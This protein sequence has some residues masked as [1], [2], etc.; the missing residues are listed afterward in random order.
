[1]CA[2]WTYKLLNAY[3]S[4]SAFRNWNKQ[5]LNLKDLNFWREREKKKEIKANHSLMK[6]ILSNTG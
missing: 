1:M 5:V 2:E 3:F 6:F 4:T